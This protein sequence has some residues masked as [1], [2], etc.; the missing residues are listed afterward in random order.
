MKKSRN[1][2]IY[3]L[4]LGITFILSAFGL[5]YILD[6]MDYGIDLQGGFEV[7]YKVES[8]DDKKVTDSMVISTY[9]TIEKRINVL[10]VSEPD[11]VIEGKDKIR[12]TLA[13]IKDEEVARSILSAAATLT[14][15]DTSDNLLMTSDVLKS[16]GVKLTA[17]DKGLPAVLLQVKNP[18]EFYRITNMVKDFSDN[19]IVIWL[20]FVEGVDAFSIEESNCGSLNAS[21]CLSAA[22]VSEAFASDVII[23]GNFTRE[24]AETLVNLI[25][26]G[27]LSTKLVEVSS[28]TVE[29]SLG[30]NSLNKTLFAGLIGLILIVILLTVLYHFA[31]FIAG[32]NV[33]IYTFISFLVY[34]L[35]GGVLTLPGIAAMILGIGM[36]VDVNVLT[37]ERI[38]EELTSG[39]SL[40]QA[41]VNGGKRAFVTILDGNLTTLIVAIILFYFGESSIK[42][43][44]TML[45][46]NIFTTIGIMLYFTRY[47]LK[48][49]I[50]SNKFN[51]KIKFFINMKKEKIRKLD[52]PEIEPFQKIDFVGKRKF[53]YAATSLIVVVGFVSL[54]IRGLNL[55]IDF[56]GGTNV[57]FLNSKEISVEEL[58]NDFNELDK[59][60]EDIVKI[61]NGEGYLIKINDVF[62]KEDEDTIKAFLFEKYEVNA[63]VE[64]ISNIVKEQMIKNALYSLLF[65]FV[66]IIAYVSLR[67]KF[68][69]AVTGIIALIHDGFIMIAMFSLFKLEVTTI[70]VSAVLLIIGYSINDTIVTYD[71]IRENL[72]DLGKKATA[73]DLER[74]VNKSL[75]ETFK[76]S[77]L[78]SI[79][80]LIPVICL[81]LLGSFELINFNIAVLIGLVAGV[82]S[83]L[84]IAS[85]LWIEIEKRN[86]KENNKNS[87][88]KK[89]IAPINEPEELRV[90]GINTH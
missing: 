8:I 23:R 33:V 44:A 72:E 1:Y 58:K 56:N 49:L 69:F 59:K 65:A 10:G 31:G 42:G 36:A 16:G 37:F 38:K 21:R 48:G 27:S 77:I 32:L 86:L 81:V 2:F 43:F 18:D 45:I 35:I 63:D 4:I 25:N 3:T 90:K 85:Q 60:V 22:T 12:V 17:D 20:D 29:A 40:P 52:E 61:N 67:Y 78:T 88:Q 73:N 75:R 83:S 76:R 89:K 55:G 70:F 28:K 74:I 13:G 71:R 84:F 47:I 11:I 53:Y 87:K 9:K 19:R 39:K 80:T 50:N 24:E 51:D 6:I 30:G 46:L 34:W 5:P 68:S 7:L 26:S 64:I 62:T 14:F 82:Y 54:F 57:S 41:F 15:R 79:S 66:G